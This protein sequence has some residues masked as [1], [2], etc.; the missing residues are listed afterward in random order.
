MSREYWAVWNPDVQKKIDENIEK[1]R[2][3]DAVINL[4]EPPPEGT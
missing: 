2:K 1:Y 4:G 3:A